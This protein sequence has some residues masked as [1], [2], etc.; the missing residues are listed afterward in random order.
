MPGSPKSPGDPRYLTGYLQRSRSCALSVRGGLPKLRTT[1]PACSS[2]CARTEQVWVH[3]QSIKKSIEIIFHQRPLGG[4]RANGGRG[5]W[6]GSQGSSGS[7]DGG[8]S[9]AAGADAS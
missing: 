1:A 4:G 7:D 9:T 3:H 5:S 6:G 2:F 8:G